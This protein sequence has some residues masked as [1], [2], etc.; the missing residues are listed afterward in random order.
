MSDSPFSRE[1]K[2]MNVR[3]LVLLAFGSLL[4]IP[5]DTGSRANA[6]LFRARKCRSQ[7]ACE[8]VQQPHRPIRF[9]QDVH[10]ADLIRVKGTD[11]V[12]VAP[13]QPDTVRTSTGK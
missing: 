7:P 2:V 5:G 13:N 12:E 4:L 8:P 9:L 11:G 10:I 1:R 6:G 3:S